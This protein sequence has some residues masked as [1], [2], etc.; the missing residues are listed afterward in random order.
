MKK[1]IILLLVVLN[2]GC[3]LTRGEIKT[4][5]ERKNLANQVTSIQKKN[6]DDQ[7]MLEQLQEEFRILSGKQQQME[8]DVYTVKEDQRKQLENSDIKLK[9][10]EQSILS[11]EQQINKLTLDLAALKVQRAKGSKSARAAKPSKGNFKLAQELFYAEKWQKAILKY[12][13][14]RELNPRGRRYIESTYKIGVCFQ[15]LKMNKA[16]RTFYS[17]VIDKYPKSKEFPKAKERLSKL[18]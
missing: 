18:K 4:A 3:L 17:E 8:Q 6:A 12:E 13:K 9:L 15:K 11:L 14:Y 1:I 16:A 5:K 7:E 2:T 10:F